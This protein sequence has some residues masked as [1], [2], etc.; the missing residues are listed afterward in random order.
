MCVC[1]CGVSEFGSK[2]VLYIFIGKDGDLTIWLQDIK[3]HAFRKVDK[4]N[5]RRCDYY[6]M[7]IH[8]YLVV[9]Q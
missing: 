1:V 2:S 6:Q 3:L 7:I 4:V 8:F 5:V 9:S